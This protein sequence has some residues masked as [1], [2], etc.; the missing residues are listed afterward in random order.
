M[1]DQLIPATPSSES[2]QL[3][4]FTSRFVRNPGERAAP[5]GAALR[6]VRR[7]A[8]SGGLTRLPSGTRA[9][10]VR[11][12]G[13][14]CVWI[15]PAGTSIG[16]GA[17]L[18][19]HGGGFVFGSP[20]SHRPPAYELARHT[21]LPVLL[22]DYRRAPECPYPAAAK[23]CLAAYRALLDKGIPA[24]KIR[25]VGDSAGGHLAAGLCNSLLRAGLG[26][27]GRVL[28]LSPLLDLSCTTALELDAVSRDPFVPPSYTIA[29]ASAYAGTTP[30][31]EP[32]LDVLSQD[33]AGWPATLI[34]SGGTE[35][36]LGDSRALA[37]QLRAADVEVELQVWPGQVHVFPVFAKWLPEGRAAT[38]YAAEFLRDTG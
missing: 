10:P 15:R 4:R 12:G 1:T 36:L 31:S 7:F 13:T 22:P 2:V 34:Q 3:A 6:A 8:D 33:K 16:D 14:P 5:R 35:C 23:D 21:G 29:A 30:R 24:S 17:L 25:L 19:L 37:E 20:R 28:L 32:G 9:W 11:Y 27:P 38:R 18:W 26:L